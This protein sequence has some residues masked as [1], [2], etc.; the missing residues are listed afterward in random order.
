MKRINYLLIVC[1]LLCAFVT[2]INEFDK[3]TVIVLKDLSIVLTLTF[4]YIIRKLFK[5]NIS[6]YFIFIWIIFIFLSHYLGVTLEF[7]FKWYMFD[8]L[9]H[10]MSGIISGVVGVLILDKVKC[11][12]VLFNILFIL[13]FT[14]FCAGMW[15]MFE[16]TCNFLFGG[17]AQ[18]VA[19]TG[20]SDTMWDMIVAF[21]GSIIVCFVYYFRRK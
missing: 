4:P 12:N 19:L 2:I 9:T 21:F 20:V 16:F 6:E 18:R 3:G 7:Y 5:I 13:S 17:D 10:F 15:E 11:K 8:K 1:I 14:W